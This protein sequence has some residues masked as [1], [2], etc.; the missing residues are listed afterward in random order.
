MPAVADA[1]PNTAWQDLAR[2]DVA[3][4]TVRMF[5]EQSH[6]VRV[7][8]LLDRGDGQRPALIECEPGEPLMISEGEDT[9]IVPDEA[10]R[11]V[12]PLA[13]EPPPAVPASALEVDPTSDEVRGPIGAVQALAGA[14]RELA[15][16]LGGRTV[17]TADFATRSGEPVTIAAREGEPVLLGLG[18]H[19][20]ALPEDSV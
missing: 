17:A 8:V 13:V 1:D 11:G 4:A 19:Q 12:T 18:D 10:L 6:A 2:H 9:F 5:A 7:A 16:A 3:I 14:V 15:R 20:F